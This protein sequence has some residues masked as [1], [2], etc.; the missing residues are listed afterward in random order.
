MASKKGINISTKHI[1]IEKA[2]STAFA[3]V[4]IASV[5]V[6]F[7]I[8]FLNILWGTARYNSKVHTAQEEVR[9]TLKANLEAVGDLENS[10]RNLEIGSDLI[11]QQ[12]TDKKNSE[13]VLDALPSKFDYP[14]LVSSINNLAKRSGVKLKSFQGTDTGEDALQ[15][16]T[17]P[18]PV[19]IPLNIQVEGSYD[20]VKQFLRAT[21]LSIRPIHVTSL[22]ISGS[23]NLLR[24]SA[25][26]NVYYQPAFDLSLTEKEVE[27]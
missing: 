1:Q 24:V 14:A 11:K 6:S 2:S 13:V 26:I 4:A 15:F 21:E 22:D 10:Y 12:P 3:A 18:A 17:T 19:E 20:R 25:G 23:D 5:L 9:D 7:S 8:V 27:E 16:S